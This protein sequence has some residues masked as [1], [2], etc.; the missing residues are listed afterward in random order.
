MDKKKLLIIGGTLLVAGVGAGIYF[1]K[2]SKSSNVEESKEEVKEKKAD[3]PK[4]EK[5]QIL[6]VKEN[7]QAR[8]EIKPTLIDIEFE[9]KKPA[10]ASET[11]TP[12]K[13]LNT[14]KE[15][16]QACGLKPLLKK[17]RTEWQKCVDAGGEASFEGD[18]DEFERD[19]MDFQGVGSYSSFQSQFDIDLD[20]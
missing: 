9:E 12:V 19:Y 11:P 6:R 7:F 16:R 3:I 1:W 14:R 20:L 13:T 18:F 2:K 17:K 8:K 15:K 5:A 4:G 10:S